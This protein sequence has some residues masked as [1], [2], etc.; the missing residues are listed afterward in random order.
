MQAVQ[1]IT[2][3][4]M[5]ETQRSHN[6]RLTIK[7]IG[8]SGYRISHYHGPTPPTVPGAPVIT[9]A[10]LVKLIENEKA[11]LI[12]VV[13]ASYRLATDLLPSAWLLSEARLHIPGSLWLPNVGFGTID[14]KFDA[15]FRNALI[16]ATRGN[17][18]Y[19][20][21][22]YC[23]TDCWGSW[24]A[25]QRAAGYGYTNRYWYDLGPEGWESAGYWLSEAMPKPL[26]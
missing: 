9:T 17:L 26:E 2:L 25:V 14:D 19:P 24:N 1:P 8:D 10:T 18:D 7:Y 11:V 12:D 15:Y 22:F 6:C 23:R 16:K 13:G 20:V 3:R 4:Y 5:S 21:V